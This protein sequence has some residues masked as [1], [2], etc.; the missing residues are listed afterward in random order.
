MKKNARIIRRTCSLLLATTLPVVSALMVN[1]MGALLSIK[2]AEAQEW[3]L[4]KK[5]GAGC[6]EI[7]GIFQNVGEDAPLNKRGSRSSPR[8]SFDVLRRGRPGSN[9]VEV[10]IET[11]NDTTLRFQYIEQSGEMSETE[12]INSACENGWRVFSFTLD[13]IGEG[14]SGVSTTNVRLAIAEDGS[15]LAHVI[16]NSRGKDFYLF[17]RKSSEEFEYRFLKTR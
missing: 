7:Q 2:G 3:L 10:A 11:L 9:I 16:R 5:V 15:L 14:Y 12:E 1:L 17:P 8:L 6:T 4:L 13:G